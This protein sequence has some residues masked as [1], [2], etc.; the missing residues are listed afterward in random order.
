MTRRNC[1][2]KENYK[3]TKPDNKIQQIQVVELPLFI[4]ISKAGS[5]FAS[6]C[7]KR[8]VREQNSKSFPPLAHVALHLEPG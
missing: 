3:F 7:F 6:I 5:N 8:K 2:Q 4:S 1:Y